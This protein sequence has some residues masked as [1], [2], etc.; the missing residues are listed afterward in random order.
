MLA[1][2]KNNPVALNNI[3]NINYLQ[4]RLEDARLAY[5]AAL[6]AV[7]GDSGIMANLARVLFQTG[8]VNEA[9]KLFRDAAEIDPRVLRQYGDL[10]A[11]LGIGK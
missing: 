9:R 5:E 11:S 7:P 1:L 6:K 2:D 8:K 10:A 4:D 3:G